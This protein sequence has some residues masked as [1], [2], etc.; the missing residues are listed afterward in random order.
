MTADRLTIP[1]LGA[2]VIC[3]LPHFLNIALWAA[4]A[5]LIL[6]SYILGAVKYSWRMPG[7]VLLVLL[8]IVFFTAAMTTQE[9][10]TIEAFVSLLALMISLK[11][12]EVR[13]G[14]DRIL[15]VILCYFLI[16]AGLFFD[17]SIGATLFLLFAILCTTAVL[18]HINQ[19]DRKTIFSLKLSGTLMA[20]ALPLAL[21]LFLL[22]PRVQ[23]GMWGRAPVNSARTGFSDTMSFGSI[24]ELALNSEVAFRVEFDGRKPAREQL[25][26]RGLVLWEFD[27]ETW[28]RGIE[29]R[30]APARVQKP[31]QRVEYTMTLE[32]HNEHWLLM[33]DLPLR[34]SYRRAW[35]NSD[36]TSYQW[37]PVTQR[38]SYSG[39]S[40]A[41]ANALQDQ[42]LPREALMLPENGNPR[43]RALAEEIAA[44][45]RSTTDFIERI[46]MYFRDHSFS[47]TLKPGPTAG[48]PIDHFLFES[49]KGFCEHFAGSFAFLMRAA[50]IPSRIV[51]GYQ[52][53]I[54][55]SYG[56]YLVVRQSDAHAWCEV[57]VPDKGWVRVDPTGAA[58]PARLTGDTTYVL[59][60]GES[61]GLL[62]L[63]RRGP[64]GEWFGATLN[65]LDFINSKWNR[66][67][68][69]YSPY[70]DLRFFDRLGINVETAKGWGQ[71]L[72]IVLLAAVATTAL[73]FAVLFLRL[74]KNDRD[75]TARA[76]D[77]YCRK[78]AAAGLPRR[79]EQGPIRYMEDVIHHRPDLADPVRAI[80]SSYIR[81]RYSKDETQA[82]PQLLKRMVR[83]FSPRSKGTR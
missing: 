83:Q 14:R 77:A 1:V 26:W 51:L 48:D 23:G 37:W 81:L 33:L 38:I 55:N 63:M 13:A 42:Q 28:R 50:G 64:F 45:S 82:E 31:S 39:I 57:W 79:P 78:L 47:Y 22:F 10:F 3:T 30:N 29:R 73:V 46:L 2:V 20:Q 11:L 41:K 4:A 12:F 18:I 8:A 16:V 27:G 5:C 74:Q 15:T 70:E 56:D 69:G 58:A 72:F 40:D 71:A 44:Q 25:Y 9:G 34:I 19:P 7:R 60:G 62:S 66:W 36:H 61:A 59:P 43:T 24:A 6:W 76:W 53:G 32:P 68:M 54:M 65:V 67:V 80:T 75:E 49:R 52:G 21:V 17:D 35:L